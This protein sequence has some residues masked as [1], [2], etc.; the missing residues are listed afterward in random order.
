MNPWHKPEQVW[1]R[2]P[3]GRALPTR[4]DAF[5]AADPPFTIEWN[6]LDAYS[7]K[8]SATTEAVSFLRLP[9]GASVALWYL[10]AK[11]AVVLIGGH[12]ELRVVARSFDDFLCAVALQKSGIPDFDSEESA[13]FV[14]PGTEGE[15]NTDG[16]EALQERFRQWFKDHTS[17]LPPLETPEAEALRR[18]VHAIAAAM[19]NDDRPK[20]FSAGGQTFWMIHYR[21]ERTPGALSVSYLDRG[22][23]YPVPTEYG[24]TTEVTA[25][26]ELVKD[27][28][29]D[30]YEFTVMSQGLVSVDRARQLLLLPPT[31]RDTQ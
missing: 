11:P 28:D 21:A 12:G 29:R 24:L 23:W 17:L 15:P 1:Q 22:V 10:E 2:V 7:L 9:D 20:A 4:F 31:D 3:K 8:S 26:L 27:K 14:V 6:D 18:R 30:R 13:P 19:T 25:L 5:V 16:L